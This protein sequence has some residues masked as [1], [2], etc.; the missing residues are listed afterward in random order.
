LKIRF[1][2]KHKEN[3]D[4]WSYYFNPV[5]TMTWLAGQSIRLE[6]PKTTWGTDERR[7]TI[8]SA[9]SEKHLRITTRLSG[10]DFK[11]SLDSLAPGDIIDGYN[12]DGTFVWG[13]EKVPRLFIAGG[14][15]ITPF[16]AMLA[17]AIEQNIKINSTLLYISSHKPILY[18]QDFNTWQ[19]T[20]ADLRV[21][22]M[23]K[24]LDFK[25]HSALATTWLNHKIYI[26]GP[27]KMVDS[28]SLAL[29][30]AGVPENNLNH[31][32]FTGIK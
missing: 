22:H 20:N 32:W 7:F 12:I 31:D 21:T 24:R 11:K 23:T 8:A 28:V 3:G 13:P 30:T 19:N 2:H 14:I 18:Q 27:S 15:G 29:I 9:P 6:L 25:T 26:S 17:Q 4:I 16:R 5:E 10:S 1:T